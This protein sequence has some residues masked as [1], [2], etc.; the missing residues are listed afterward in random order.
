M[1]TSNMF[2]LVVGVAIVGVMLFCYGDAAGEMPVQLTGA[3][4]FAAGSF[5]V[6]ATCKS[7]DGGASDGRGREKTDR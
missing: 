4:L 1:T 7:E 6:I 2:M 3:A 5:T